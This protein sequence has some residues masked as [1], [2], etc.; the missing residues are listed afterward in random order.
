MMAVQKTYR[1]D[2][3]GDPLKL[4]GLAESDRAI[5]IYWK[6]WPKGW[7]MRSAREVEKHLCPACVSSIQA[8]PA[9]CGHGY[10]CRGGP[11]CSSDHQ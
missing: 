3:C 8:M 6:S 2:L 1:C 10:E 5:G 11:Q 9:I 7:E 4:D